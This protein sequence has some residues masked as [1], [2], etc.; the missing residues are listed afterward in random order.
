MNR[1]LNRQTLQEDG[2]AAEE[3][4][5]DV[6]TVRSGQNHEVHQVAGDCCTRRSAHGVMATCLCSDP[7][8]VALWQHVYALIPNPWRYAFKECDGAP[9]AQITSACATLVDA[10][11]PCHVLTCSG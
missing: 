7:K 6:R 9:H 2:C 8:P 11:L 5:A 1:Y 4:P 3:N 10:S